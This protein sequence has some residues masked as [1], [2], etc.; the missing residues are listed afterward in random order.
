MIRLTIPNFFK[1]DQ[2]NDKLKIH[3][4]F[5]HLKKYIEELLYIISVDSQNL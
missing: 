4:Y 1:K 2:W 3:I 5:V